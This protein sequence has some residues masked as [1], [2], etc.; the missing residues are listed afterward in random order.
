MNNIKENYTL[1]DIIKELRLTRKN[2]PTT[3]VI[4]SW[5][6]GTEFDVSEGTLNVNTSYE[7]KRYKSCKKFIE[8]TIKNKLL[9]SK[10][11][12][13]FDK[14]Y[15]YISL[16]G[17]IEL[18]NQ[19]KIEC[20][21]HLVTKV[22][23][24]KGC[25]KYC[26]ENQ[27]GKP[28][29]WVKLPAIVMPNGDYIDEIKKFLNAQPKL[30]KISNDVYKVNDFDCVNYIKEVRQTIFNTIENKWFAFNYNKDDN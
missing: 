11:K 18:H 17:T 5:L 22:L 7:Y 26:T 27:I 4:I 20:K 29:N 14:I 2:V 10:A 28:Q 6:K 25:D 1:S 9:E 23:S 12:N 21:D 13:K 8:Q 30:T 15:F 24:P 3:K 16:G 19:I